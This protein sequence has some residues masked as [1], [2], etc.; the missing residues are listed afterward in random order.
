MAFTCNVIK[1]ALGVIAL[2]RRVGVEIRFLTNLNA[3]DCCKTT[4]TNETLIYFTTIS[5]KPKTHLGSSK[6]RSL[7]SALLGEIHAFM[8]DVFCIC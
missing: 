7:K 4:T 8:Q 6:I 3:V 1:V 5:C 2:K